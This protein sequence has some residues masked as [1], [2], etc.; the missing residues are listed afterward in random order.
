[1]GVS[2]FWEFAGTQWPARTGDVRRAGAVL[3][4]RPT[5]LDGGF[6]LVAEVRDD[7]THVPVW[8]IGGAA[9][10]VDEQDALV[11]L[12]AST[13]RQTVVAV[14]CRETF[15][16]QDLRFAQAPTEEVTV[17]VAGQSSRCVTRV[18]SFRAPAPSRALPPS[19]E[20]PTQEPT[21]EPAKGRRDPP[22]TAS[23]GDEQPRT[24]Q[25]ELEHCIAVGRPI[26]DCLAVR[27]VCV[28]GGTKVAPSVLGASDED[29]CVHAV[30]LCQRNGGDRV[31]CVLAAS[32]CQAVLPRAEFGNPVPR[33]AT[34]T[35]LRGG[36]APVERSPCEAFLIGCVA[37][38]TS[39]DQLG[40]CQ[41]GYFAC[42]QRAR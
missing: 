42:A 37:A 30:R 28:R 4:F 8:P 27:D 32:A 12:P 39:A 14:F 19:D 31:S 21:V 22:S 18:L 23:A 33:P 24:C 25:K 6:L 16:F 7:G 29:D 26:R 13:G 38:T 2:P 5:T 9:A 15:R 41:L 35:A 36:L 1:M 17:D 11:E 20:P 10:A 3:G 40:R 34:G